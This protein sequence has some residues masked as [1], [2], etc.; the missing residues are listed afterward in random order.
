[1]IRVPFGKPTETVDKSDKVH[2]LI[3]RLDRSRADDAI[4]PRGWATPYD[5]P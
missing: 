3:D 4:D 1:M 2:T 5:N